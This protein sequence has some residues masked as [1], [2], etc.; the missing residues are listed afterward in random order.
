MN[1]SDSGGSRP[2]GFPYACASA[3]FSRRTI[4]NIGTRRTSAAKTTGK[5]NHDYVANHDDENYNNTRVLFIRLTSDAA[6]RTKT[7]SICF[8]VVRAA[9]VLYGGIFFFF[10]FPLRR[11]ITTAPFNFQY[12]PRSLFTR[13]YKI[14]PPPPPIII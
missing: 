7:K 13:C 9:C 12:L 1:V 14:N 3:S 5:G 11:N 4:E 8:L 10:F 6:K 2:I